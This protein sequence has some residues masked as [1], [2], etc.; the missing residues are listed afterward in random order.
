MLVVGAGG[1]WCLRWVQGMAGTVLGW[2]WQVTAVSG[3][4]TAG[5]VLGKQVWRG[6]AGAGLGLVRSVLGLEP[7]GN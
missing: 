2:L 7:S 3:Q 4:G 1:Y 5:F 6:Y